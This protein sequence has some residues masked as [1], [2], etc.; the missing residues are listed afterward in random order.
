MVSFVWVL[1]RR[2]RTPCYLSPAMPMM[3][4]RLSYEK[5]AN[6]TVQTADVG[7][8]ATE[9]QSFV[10]KTVEIGRRRSAYNRKSLYYIRTY[11]LSKCCESATS[12]NYAHKRLTIAKNE[13]LLD[14]ASR[15]CRRSDAFAQGACMTH[16][17]GQLRMPELDPP[18][19]LTHDFPR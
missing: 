17:T 16:I 10:A 6:H 15:R 2:C 1:G 3:L 11:L 19:T 9:I 18:V 7:F 8:S 12:A 5:T 13:R 4:A 14:P